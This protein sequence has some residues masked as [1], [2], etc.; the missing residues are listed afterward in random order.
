[1]NFTEA[2]EVFHSR[3]SIGGLERFQCSLLEHNKIIRSQWYDR[4]QH[5]SFLFN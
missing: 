4:A 3:S 1:M 2:L 5:M